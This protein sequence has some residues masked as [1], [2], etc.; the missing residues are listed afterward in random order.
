MVNAF[1]H[2][3]HSVAGHFRLNFYAAVYHLVHALRRIGSDS[4]VALD[5][6]LQQHRFLARYLEQILPHIP[7]ELSWEDILPWWQSEISTWESEAVADLPLAAF[8]REGGLGFTGRLAL[9]IVALGEEDS[10]FGTL[11]ETLQSPLAS[12][13]P[14]LELVGQMLKNGHTDA[15]VD[16]WTICRDLLT[17]GLIEV[18]NPEAPRS[19]WTIKLPSS[20]WRILRGE[21]GGDLLPGCRLLAA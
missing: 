13:R 3:E 7:D 9:M 2:I 19:E 10:R 20:V 18:T 5:K 14:S 4:G 16:G 1:S 21:R 11:F 15:Q 12:R 17:A 8:S 6:T